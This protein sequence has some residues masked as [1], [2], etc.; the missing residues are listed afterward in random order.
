MLRAAGW[1]VKK[2]NICQV[3]SRVNDWKGQGSLAARARGRK[4]P[5]S[6]LSSC[7]R[8]AREPPEEGGSALF[9]F[10]LKTLLAGPLLWEPQLTSEVLSLS[11]FYN[12]TPAVLHGT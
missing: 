10:L 9:E 4:Y 5:V 3:H 12:M 11:G 1:S 7:V 6:I 8:L 2:Q